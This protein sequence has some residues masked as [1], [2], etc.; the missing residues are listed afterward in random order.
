MKTKTNIKGND[1]HTGSEKDR[2]RKKMKILIASLVFGI[3][4]SSGAI[5]LWIFFAETSY[6]TVVNSDG[7]PLSF[8]LP[9]DDAVIDVSSAGQTLNS[10][11][12]IQNNNGQF[13]ANITL[14]SQVETTNPLCNST[15]GDCIL[16]WTYQN[17]TIS[18]GSII[19]IPSSTS[20]LSNSFFCRQNS[21]PI[22]WT[23]SVQITSLD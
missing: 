20:V 11:A 4:L 5:A 8:S 19:T 22:N 9:F 7:D 3:L 16:N 21:C 2:H 1:K 14:F 18:D 15:D 23:N 6:T 17:E 10:S 12:E 13:D